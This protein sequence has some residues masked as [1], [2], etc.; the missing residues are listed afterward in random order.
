MF[1]NSIFAFRIP[2]RESVHKF[3][4]AIA[5]NHGSNGLPILF[6]AGMR[7]FRTERRKIPRIPPQS[8]RSSCGIER[9]DD[10]RR[11]PGLMQIPDHREFGFAWNFEN[12][13]ATCHC[14]TAAVTTRDLTDSLSRQSS[15]SASGVLHINPRHCLR[16]ALES[17]E[18]RE[19]HAA[20]L[21]QWHESGL[22]RMV[23][24]GHR[25][26]ARQSGGLRPSLDILGGHRQ[27]NNCFSN[28]IPSFFIFLYSVVRLMPSIFAVSWRFHP[29]VSNASRMICFSGLVS[30]DFRPPSEL[31]L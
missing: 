17:R 15:S 10:R 5:N 6:Y 11:R 7:Y 1:R 16:N 13:C 19:S 29:L 8:G 20:L 28:S 30:A 24:R 22:K 14:L 31:K 9:T 3:R 2:D 25:C 26:I 4:T 18:I 23:G 21:K 12:C 27:F